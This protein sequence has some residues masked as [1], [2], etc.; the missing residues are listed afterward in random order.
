VQARTFGTLLEN[1]KRIG[2]QAEGL[3]HKAGKCF[4]INVEQT[5]GLRFH[6]DIAARDSF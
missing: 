3:L 4:R 5:F 2:S 6:S 1:L